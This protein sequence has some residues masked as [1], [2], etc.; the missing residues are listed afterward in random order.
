M[1]KDYD[2]YEI[3]KKFQCLILNIRVN[4]RLKQKINLIRSSNKFNVY[5]IDSI[6]EPYNIIG[7]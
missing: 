3:E 1:S 2:V 7:N 5:C 6:R 4:K